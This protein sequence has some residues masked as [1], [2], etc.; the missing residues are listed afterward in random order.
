M[1]AGAC[2]RRPRRVQQLHPMPHREESGASR[3]DVLWQALGALG[4]RAAARTATHTHTHME[5]S[6]QWLDVHPTRAPLEH[7][8]RVQ[9]DTQK[10]FLTRPHSGTRRS[11]HKCNTRQDPPVASGPHKGRRLPS[12]CAEEWDEEKM[13]GRGTVGAMRAIELHAE[14]QRDPRRARAHAAQLKDCGW[15]YAWL[16]AAESPSRKRST[17]R[18]LRCWKR[19]AAPRSRTSCT[20][21][22]A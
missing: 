16:P 4:A 7:R 13:G 21:T 19:W 3:R 22:G 12:C 10:G 15:L 9:S 5:P 14:V 17:S 2:V 6:V 1:A 18:T 8:W 11:T 20:A